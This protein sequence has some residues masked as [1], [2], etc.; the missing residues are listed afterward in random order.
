MASLK[1]GF[2]GVGMGGPMAARLLKAGYEVTVFDPAAASVEALVA[3]GAKAAASPREVGDATEIVLISLPSPQI[4][5]TAALSPDGI[6][7]GKSVR[8]LVDLSTTGAH[9]L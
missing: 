6:A 7:D 8:I 9:A 4:L 5:E 1:A 2:V 3:Q